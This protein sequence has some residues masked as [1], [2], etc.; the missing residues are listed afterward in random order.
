MHLNNQAID[1]ASIEFMPIDYR[2]EN[3]QLESA[4]F[5]NGQAL[6]D[7]QLDKLADQYAAELHYIYVIERA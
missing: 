4:Q 2:N 3:V 5:T 1:Q 6:T 7:S